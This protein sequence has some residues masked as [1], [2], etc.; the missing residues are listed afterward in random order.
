[1]RTRYIKPGFFTNDVLA[2]LPP[3]DRLLWAGLWT[4]ADREGRLEDRPKKIKA[5]V[6]PYDDHDVDAALERL[7][8]AGFISR[9]VH[10]EGRYIQIVNFVRHQNPHKHEPESTIPG[11]TPENG[12]VTDVYTTTDNVRS[13]TDNV[14]TAT[15]STL[16]INP[17]NTQTE[18]SNPTSSPP[19]PPEGEGDAPDESDVNSEK[20]TGYSKAFLVFWEAYP[21]SHR[22][23]GKA[24]SWRVWRRHKLGPPRMDRLM[25]ALE[26]D[27]ASPDW[28]K[29]GGEFIPT[30]A[31]WLNKQRWLDDPRPVALAPPVATFP[32]PIPSQRQKNVSDE[33]LKEFLQITEA[34]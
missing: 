31:A 15:A 18:N 7:E 9:Y 13:S 2:E 21:A 25:A 32:P 26:E 5:S 17:T 11:Q 28:V 20:E 22:K 29:N 24:D 12:T 10:G 30:P 14:G 3:L 27:R 8:E 1:M 34:R 23:V 16:T 6:L 33:S 4:I 19:T